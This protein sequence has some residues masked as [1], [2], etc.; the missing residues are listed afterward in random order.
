L[1]VAAYDRPVRRYLTWGSDSARWEGFEFRPGDIIISTPAKAGTTWM[2]TLVGLLIFGGDDW[3]ASIDDLS[4]WLDMLTRPIDDVRALLAAQTHRRFIKTHTPLDGLPIRDDVVYVVVG[5][6]P[7]EI[8]I[9]W[10][11]HL[12]SLNVERIVELRNAVVGEDGEDEDDDEDGPLDD[13]ADT[14]ATFVSECEP[15]APPPNLTN[16]LHHLDTGWQLRD[17]PNVGLFHYSDMLADLPAELRRLAQL[18]SIEL[19]RGQAEALAAAAG[20]DAMRRDVS[21][22]VPGAAQGYWHDPVMFLRSAKP[23]EWRTV[24]RASDLAAYDELVA[25]LVPP[26]FGTWVHSG[27]RALTA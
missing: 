5:R 23:G 1:S 10:H 19:T 9:S 6:D 2:Q 4:P 17:Q 14:F 11:H 25:R 3:P 26:E 20:I 7:R 22:R 18:L 8:A 27:R 24:A 21:R 16:V 12:L 15:M 13:P